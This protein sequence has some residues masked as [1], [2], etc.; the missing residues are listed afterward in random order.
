MLL[1]RHKG[2]YAQKDSRSSRQA[3][4][5]KTGPE[6]KECFSTV[7]STHTSDNNNMQRGSCWPPQ[8]KKQDG[9]FEFWQS[10]QLQATTFILN[11]CIK[12]EF[13]PVGMIRKQSKGLLTFSPRNKNSNLLDVPMYFCL[14]LI[15]I[16][17]H[18]DL[19]FF[20]LI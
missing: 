18:S 11:I 6:A 7:I 2:H 9:N 19:S 8:L 17:M 1:P 3:F 10:L 4:L 20:H 13:N 15:C 14:A 5:H 16:I 12:K